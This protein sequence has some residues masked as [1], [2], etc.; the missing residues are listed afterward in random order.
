MPMT[1]CEEEKKKR[2]RSAGAKIAV[3]QVGTEARFVAYC[4]IRSLPYTDQ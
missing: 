2:A 1:L 3:A 4:C